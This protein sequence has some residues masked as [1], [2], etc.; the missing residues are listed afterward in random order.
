MDFFSVHLDNQS[1][2]P[3]YLQIINSIEE[4][5]EKGLLKQGSKLPSINDIC[6]ENGLARETV[7]KAFSRLK[8]RG[9]IGSVRGKGFYI[10]S[11]TLDNIRNIF[12]LF[13]AFTAYK[14]TLYKSLRQH[15]GDK[16]RVDLFFHHYNLRVFKSL[17]EE[18]AGRYTDYVILPFSDKGINNI[19]KELPSRKVYLV[20][21]YPSEIQ[22]GMS[23]VY[24]AFDEDIYHAL[25]SAKANLYKYHRLNFIF[26]NQITDLPLELISG[27]NHFCT[28]NGIEGRICYDSVDQISKGEAYIVVDDEDLVDL[29]LKANQA[30]LWFGV[31]VGIISYNETSMKKVAWTGVSVISTDFALMGKQLAQMILEGRNETIKNPCSFI[32]RGSF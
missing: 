28:E 27:F 19:L 12:V 31:D 32:D 3:K 22:S 20:D 14:E 4:G 8:E 16:G 11:T 15:L 18:N 29:I 2:V 9:I 13:D 21:R 25:E 7:V 30:G 23:A 10:A 17:V 5:I 1:S 24:Q 6:D 26:R